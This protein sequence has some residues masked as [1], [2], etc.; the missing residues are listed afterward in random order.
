MALV[1]FHR[2]SEGELFVLH[3][4]SLDHDR[5][6]APSNC[7]CLPCANSDNIPSST[8]PLSLDAEVVNDYLR[9]LPLFTGNVAFASQPSVFW[10]RK[11]RAN[12][13]AV[14]GAEASPSTEPAALIILGQISFE[15]FWADAT[16]GYRGPS[17][18]TGAIT[19]VKASLKLTAPPTVAFKPLW[20]ASIKNIDNLAGAI[21]VPG[22]NRLGFS[23]SANCRF[24]HRPFV[25]RSDHFFFL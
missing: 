13:V 17:R 4:Q 20:N 21:A 16:G 7:P 25:V 23:A 11:E 14:S 5:S 22:L 9:G 19:D 10:M 15:D 12:I 2:S 24:S 3:V 18:F 8:A 6:D 1:L